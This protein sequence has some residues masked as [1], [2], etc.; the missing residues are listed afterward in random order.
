MYQLFGTS[1]WVRMRTTPGTASAADRSTSFSSAWWRSDRAILRCS[2]PVG[3]TSSKNSVPPVTCPRASERWTGVPMTSNPS[4]RS[5]EKNDLSSCSLWIA[6]AQPT[7]A[8]RR[9]A[10]SSTALMIDS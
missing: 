6:I 3:C 4:S 1:A 7:T 5:P 2:S 9:P 10:A 8:A